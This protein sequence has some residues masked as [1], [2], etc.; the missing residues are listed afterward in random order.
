MGD[1]HSASEDEKRVCDLTS[2]GHRSGG[3][4]GFRCRGLRRHVGAHSQP[5]S[6]CPREQQPRQH[7]SSVV[8]VRPQRGSAGNQLPEREIG[9]SSFS[10]IVSSS[11]DNSRMG[12]RETRQI[13]CAYSQIVRSDE[14]FP[15]RATLRIDI[16]L[17]WVGSWYTVLTS[18]CVSR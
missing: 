5:W 18:S 10:P 17:H 4:R 1:L 9:W 11:C 13:S 14:N 7:R 16:R 6:C 8:S 15:D 2:A 3:P 12:T